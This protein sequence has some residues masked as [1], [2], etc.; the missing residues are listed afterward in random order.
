MAS[1]DGGQG[2]YSDCQGH[3]SV[4]LSC[5]QVTVKFNTI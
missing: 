3:H 5:P 4:R 1:M 2:H